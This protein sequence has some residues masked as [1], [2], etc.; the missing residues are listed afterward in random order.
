MTLALE[1]RHA[2][3]LPALDLTESNPT[4]AGFEYPEAEILAALADPR[5]LLYE[6]RPFGLESAR[7]AIGDYYRERGTPIDAS[8]IILTASTSEAYSFLFKL[9]ADPG[10][11]ALVPQ[12]SY[13]LFD[14]LAR[15]EGLST[16]PYPL[17]FD[18][19]WR[20]DLDRLEAA[21]T[22]ASRA[23]ILVSPNNPTGSQLKKDEWQALSRI[24]R[25]R[26]LALIWDEVFHDYRLDAA[27][28][29]FDP[30]TQHETPVFVL[31][32]LSKTVA[33]PQVKLGWIAL[34]GPESF[35]PGA[36]ERLEI[37][38]DTYL[39]VSTQVQ[40]ATAPLLALRSRIQSQL[41]ARLQA[42]LGSLARILADSPA[43]ALPVEAGWYAVIRLPGTRSE[44]DWVVEL[45]ETHG[46][47]THPGY[48]YD[49][50]NAPFIVVSLLP[51]PQVFAQ[52]I[53]ALDEFARR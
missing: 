43:R 47:L 22:G 38:A 4:R 45:L 7:Q 35:R 2:A 8:Q 23:I 29:A 28:D 46:V 52:A 21:L 14:F 39:S 1:K 3:G 20:I 50:E 41:L 34:A 44:E 36:L 9:L 33:L 30:L 15:L 24:C 49:F 32:G 16:V 18:G 12:P 25:D 31:N 53:S 27:G 26:G 6:P 10:A 5:L 51:S 40:H 17:V 13:P 42:N 37:I 19:V 48:F 11:E